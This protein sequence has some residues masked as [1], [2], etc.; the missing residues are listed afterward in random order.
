M[1]LVEFQ[2]AMGRLVRSPTGP[3]TF[4][5]LTLDEAEWSCIAALKRS[6]GYRF[7]L[8]VQRSWCVRRARRASFQTL[9][10][11]SAELRSRLIDDWIESGG[12]TSSFAAV[13][14]DA[15]LDF[16]AK[17]LPSPSHEL[18]L[19]RFE[20]ATIRA[21]EGT[22][23]FTIPETSVI[24]SRGC[25]IQRG[26]YAGITEFYGEPQLIMEA[27]SEQRLLPP[28]SPTVQVVLLFGPGLEGL[29]RPASLSE[30][31]LWEELA[32]PIEVS[33]LLEEGHCRLGIEQ[34]I[35]GGILEIAR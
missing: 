19:C 33:C 31:A 25:I 14:A 6:A 18:T 26:R 13:E 2:S 1:S 29:C 11:L 8:G 20:Q 21:D 23:G 16:I 34:A 35:L 5:T 12:G 28:V 17:R 15:M 7:T 4:R 10:I 32:M 3:D 24:D 22:F 9:S 30:I 27:L